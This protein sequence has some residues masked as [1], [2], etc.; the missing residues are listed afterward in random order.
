MSLE[1]EGGIAWPST[2]LARWQFTS[3]DAC[4]TTVLPDGCRDLI[5]HVDALGR[6]RWHV[7]PL[8]DAAMDV[9]G[10][11]GERWLGYRMQPGALLDA[12]GLLRS[13]QTI[14]RRPPLSSYPTC[15]PSDGTD[16]ELEAAVLAAMGE[17]TRLDLR[18]QEVLH[19]LAQA[20][21]VGHAARSLGVS[22]R[23]LERLTHHATARPPRFWLALARVRRAARALVNAQPLVAIAADHG[24]ADQAHFSRECRRWLGQTPT[25]LRRC[26]QLLTTATQPGYG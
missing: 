17:H 14:L 12:A 2:L 1:K 11:A 3:V 25:M 10:K 4:A 24:Y 8:T 6:P 5:L 21:T 16:A 22:E 19:A 20:R 18:V 9:P 23:C 7:S 13:V 15:H 26:P